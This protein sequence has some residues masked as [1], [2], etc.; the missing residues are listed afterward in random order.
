V[1]LEV[2]LVEVKAEIVEEGPV[3][4]AVVTGDV[5]LGALDELVLP[6]VVVGTD[7]VGTDVEVEVVVTGATICGFVPQADRQAATAPASA[8]EVTWAQGQRENLRNI[9]RST[10]FG[11]ARLDQV[12]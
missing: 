12:T 8:A 2:V 4:E 9:S 1:E 10:P 6:D 3:T 5:G 7:V 11:S